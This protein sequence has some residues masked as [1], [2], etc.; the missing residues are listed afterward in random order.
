M[1]A[2]R[3][4]GV[5][6]VDKRLW[7]IA[8]AL[9]VALVGIPLALTRDDSK[10]P[11][12]PRA[13]A[14]P[15]AP[16]T[17]GSPAAQVTVTGLAGRVSGPSRNPFEQQHVPSAAPATSTASSASSGAGI[18]SS[19]GSASTGSSGTSTNSTQETTVV[20]TQRVFVSVLRFGPS[21]GE[22]SLRRLRPGW[23]LPSTANPFIVYLGRLPNSR[24]V[25][26]M[27]SADVVPR[28]EGRCVDSREVCDVVALA[29]GDIEYFDRPLPN[30]G[31]VRYRLHFFRTYLG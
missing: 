12:T 23:G 2:V 31:T 30:G 11:V 7:P 8:V 24:S 26:F 9:I 15:G 20:R 4:L 10:T 16:V 21:G 17:P 18:G 14:A 13:S 27:I 28:G 5:D 25:A 22:S 29:P 1:N 6:L 3:D 19:S